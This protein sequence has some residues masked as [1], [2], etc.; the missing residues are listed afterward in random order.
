MSIESKEIKDIYALYQNLH[1]RT[2][3][4]VKAE[5]EERKKNIKDPF[6]N[7]T[8]EKEDGTKIFKVLSLSY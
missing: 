5:R 3:A 6:R 2:Y 4:E 8:I 1:E 7:T